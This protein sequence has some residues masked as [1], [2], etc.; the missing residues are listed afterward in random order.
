MSFDGLNCEADFVVWH[1]R[2]TVGRNSKPVLVIGEA[3]SLGQGDLIQD[4]DVDKM[5]KIGSKLPGSII[6]ISVLK[7]QF[8]KSEQ[9]RL[10]K[11]VRWGRRLNDE[12]ESTNPVLLLTQT[13]LL[14]NG[15]FRYAWKEKDG[16]YA[17]FANQF[18]KDL[19]SIADA[20][21]KIY[22]GLPTFQEQ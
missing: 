17:E 19:T 9:F 15:P 2:G 1:S 12:G 20:T 3:K 6:A 22:L 18:I 11:L 10:R 13:E 14:S 8:S 21:V 7:D 5:K 16:A 4:T